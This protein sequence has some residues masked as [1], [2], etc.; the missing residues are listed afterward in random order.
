[1]SLTSCPIQEFFLSY[2]NHP[3]LSKKWMVKGLIIKSFQCLLTVNIIFI[4]FLPFSKCYQGN[5]FEFL[6]FL[7]LVLVQFSFFLWASMI[8]LISF[9]GF[10][11]KIY[12]FDDV[13]RWLNMLEH[14]LLHHCYQSWCFALFDWSV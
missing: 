13:G 8:T 11:L 6:T 5:I 14:C 12:Y 10:G 4:V 1:M 2:C 9:S 7:S 3:F